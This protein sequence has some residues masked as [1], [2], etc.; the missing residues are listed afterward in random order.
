MS[1]TS[2]N[3]L[4]Y[5]FLREDEYVQVDLVCVHCTLKTQVNSLCMFHIFGSKTLSPTLSLRTHTHTPTMFKQLAAHTL[6]RTRLVT[7]SFCTSMS[8]TN[9]IIANANDGNKEPRDK[10]A[11]LLALPFPP[12][13]ELV[14]LASYRHVDTNTIYKVVRHSFET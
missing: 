3:R 6:S 9:A 8:T 12:G 7:P 10:K 4:S 1:L 5:A 14:P 2:T 11:A 13:T